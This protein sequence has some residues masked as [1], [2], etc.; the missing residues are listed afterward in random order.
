MAITIAA[1][2]GKRNDIAAGID[3]KRSRTP[4]FTSLF[5]IL[6]QLTD[7]AAVQSARKL[8]SGRIMGLT[9]D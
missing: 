6:C 1:I 2:P 7:L 3:I 5:R 8:I 4:S 9:H